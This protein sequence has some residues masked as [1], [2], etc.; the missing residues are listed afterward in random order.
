MDSESLFAT[1]EMESVLN[2]E[3]T[4]FTVLEVYEARGRTL[5]LVV[6]ETC[7]QQSLDTDR[8]PP[9]HGFEKVGDALVPFPQDQIPAFV[10]LA[11][12]Q[13]PSVVSVSLEGDRAPTR[14][15]EKLLMPLEGPAMEGLVALCNLTDDQDIR[16]VFCRNREDGSAGY[17]DLPESFASEARAIAKRIDLQRRLIRV[18]W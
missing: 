6:E 5:L 3:P 13:L 8:L 9:V 14:F 12:R 11:E 15:E 10:A 17:V 16:V 18:Y 7:M 4:S 1:I 2:G